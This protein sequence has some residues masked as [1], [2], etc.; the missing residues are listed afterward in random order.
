MNFPNEVV[1]KAKKFDKISKTVNRTPSDEDT[2][3]RSDAAT[4]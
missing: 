4:R 2:S 1:S 3:V